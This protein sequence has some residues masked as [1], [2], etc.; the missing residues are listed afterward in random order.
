M[1]QNI[2]SE[3]GEN[4]TLSSFSEPILIKPEN[5]QTKK[6]SDSQNVSSTTI[7]PYGSI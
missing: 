3:N 1:M 6:V 7:K 2:M 4:Q 5:G